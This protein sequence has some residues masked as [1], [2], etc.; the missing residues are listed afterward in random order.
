MPGNLAPWLGREN[1]C[2][3]WNAPMNWGKFGGLGGKNV[4]KPWNLACFANPPQFPNLWLD[5]ANPLLCFWYLKT[6]VVWKMFELTLKEASQIVGGGPSV[7]KKC[8]LWPPIG[9]GNG[10]PIWPRGPQKGKGIWNPLPP[11]VRRQPQLVCPTQK[12]P[13]LAPTPLVWLWNGR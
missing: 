1:P 8:A 2:P 11:F 5:L 6:L 3:I 9:I 13:L 12:P 7:G 10:E 4:G